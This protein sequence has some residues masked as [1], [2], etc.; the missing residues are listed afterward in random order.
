MRYRRDKIS[1]NVS[2]FQ[3]REYDDKIKQA[4]LY[5]EE[6]YKQVID[7]VKSYTSNAVTWLDAGCGIGKMADLA[8]RQVKIEK[9][10]FCDC[11]AEMLEIAKGRFGNS[12]AEFCKLAIQ[13]LALEESFDVITAIQVNHYLKK[14]ERKRAVKNCY[15]VLKEN[16]IYISFEN[17]AP[18]SS[19]GKQLYLDRWKSYQLG[20]GK[21]QRRMRQAYK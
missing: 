13:D 14:E 15:K 18:F 5:Y 2:A 3:A 12:N 7:V 17:F 6:F 21:R 16:G 20:Q 10:V 4:L 1:D 19:A 11:S 9:F 8:Y